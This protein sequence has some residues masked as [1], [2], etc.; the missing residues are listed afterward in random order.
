MNVS[1]VI[2]PLQI[3]IILKDMKEFI[4]ERNL[5]NVIDMRKPLHITVISK[6]INEHIVERSPVIVINVLKPL[7]VNCTLQ[8]LKGT[9]VLPEHLINA[10]NVKNALMKKTFQQSIKIYA[11]WR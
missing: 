9:Q 4:L 11:C 2:K 8:T 3:R 10:V 6:Y 1:C 5:M 7:H